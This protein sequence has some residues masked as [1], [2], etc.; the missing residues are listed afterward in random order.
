MEIN[1]I[2]KIALR[3]HEAAEELDHILDQ[4]VSDRRFK[5]KLD[6]ARKF[7][8]LVDDA[9]LLGNRA[10]RKSLEVPIELKVK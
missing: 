7:R 2:E 8:D 10:W 1:T 3:Y 5:L 4:A 9:E 6:E